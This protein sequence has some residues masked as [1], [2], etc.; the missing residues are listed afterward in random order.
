[1]PKDSPWV[2]LDLDDANPS[3]RGNTE[4][5]RHLRD[6]IDNAIENGYACMEEYD[7]NFNQIKICN[8]YPKEEKEG[9]L[10]RLIMI[11]CGVIFIL[12]I[13]LLISLLIATLS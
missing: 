9:Y 13:I 12:G 2:R 3:I 8:G 4:G 10:F 11:F 7:C 5:M 1:M 6:K